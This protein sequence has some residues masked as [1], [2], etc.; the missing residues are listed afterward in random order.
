MEKGE[1]KEPVINW[2]E[3]LERIKNSPYYFYTN[4]FI[5][6]GRPATTHLNE[7]EFNKEW[8]NLKNNKSLILSK[9]RRRI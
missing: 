6:E 8:E 2:K 1:D 7:E 9:N 4:F 5:V 3:E